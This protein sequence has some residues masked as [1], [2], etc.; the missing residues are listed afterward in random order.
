MTTTSRKVML[1]AVWCLMRP[2]FRFRVEGR[3]NIPASNALFAA[4]HTSLADSVLLWL[5]TGR[6]LGFLA[7]AGLYRIPILRW[8]L[9]LARCIPVDRHAF[10]R[11]GAHDG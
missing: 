2:F 4:N 6:D 1:W 10:G 9:R 8:V 5:A 7:T 11:Q 3:E